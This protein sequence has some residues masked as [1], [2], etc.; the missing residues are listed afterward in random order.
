VGETRVDLQHLLEDLRDAYVGSLEETI[1]TEIVANGLDAGAPTISISTDPVAVTL[2]VV[3]EGRGMRR[4]ELARYH[5]IASSSNKRGDGIGFAGVGIKL[6]LLISQE[7]FTETRRAGTHAA[8]S[9]HLRSRYRAPWKW[10]PPPGLA[11]ARGTAVRLTLSNPLSPLLDAGFLEETIRRHFEP[12]LNPTFDPILKRHYP[13]G[14]RF[15][16]DRQPVLPVKEP[17]AEI[18]PVAIRLARKRTPSATGYLERYDTPLSDDRSGIA[19]S[20]FGKVIKRGWDWLG[21]T[22]VAPARI[23]GL[24]EVPELAS[25]LTLNKNDFLRSGA[26]GAMYLGYRKAL[27]EVVS[28]QLAEWDD[29]RTESETAPPVRLDRDLERVLED[30]AGDFPLLHSLV[31]RRPGGQKRLPMPDLSKG[32]AMSP[33]LSLIR[34]AEA[35]PERPDLPADSPASP[36]GPAS[37]DGPPERPP[38]PNPADPEPGHE[39]GAVPSSGSTR[40]R[41]QYGLTIRF[42]R[43]PDDAE[44]GRL[45]ENTILVNDAHPAY[46]RAQSSRSMG[47]HLALTVALALAPLAV[48]PAEEHLFITRFMAEWGVVHGGKSS[49]RRPT[50]RRKR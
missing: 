19:I 11:P 42:E 38:A 31:E 40:R 1:L 48:A 8:S 13:N 33:L 10:V 22:P 4:R 34:G 45:V 43:H 44:L 9:W 26:R 23:A 29:T 46:E 5:D 28:R 35:E 6:G 3:D 25:C 49:R 47:Y 39:A 12:L 37:P 15:Q 32:E 17:S 27:Q 14:I 16:I 24:I 2:T 36:S 20:T 30:L 7:V 41:T 21:V 50:T 18:V